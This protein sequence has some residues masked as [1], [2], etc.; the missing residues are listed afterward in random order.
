MVPQPGGGLLRQGGTN[1]GGPG[2]TRSE[3]QQL[4]R[5]KF[6]E[7]ALDVLVGIAHGPR[8]VETDCPECGASV[9]V[10]DP[11]A[12]DGER[13][14]AADILLRYGTGTPAD[15]GQKLSVHLSLAPPPEYQD[16]DG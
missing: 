1:R 2:R 8:A 4:I 15:D 5:D 10:E 16:D 3:I 13:V 7:G 9:T 11:P 14:R 6:T 12:G